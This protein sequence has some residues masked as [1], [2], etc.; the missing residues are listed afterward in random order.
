MAR[1]FP[2]NTIYMTYEGVKNLK[3]IVSPSLFP[4]TTK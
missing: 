4:K 2:E 3:E 1:I